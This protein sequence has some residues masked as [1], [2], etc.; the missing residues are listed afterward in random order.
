MGLSDDYLSDDGISASFNMGRQAE[1]EALVAH[2]FAEVMKGYPANPKIDEKI[3]LRAARIQGR[4]PTHTRDFLVSIVA[5]WLS[6]RAAPAAA[7][8]ARKASEDFGGLLSEIRQA[9]VALEAM[10]EALRFADTT[11]RGRYAQGLAQ[12]V[13]GALAGAQRALEEGKEWSDELIDLI[14]AGAKGARGIV[15]ALCHRGAHEALAV[16]VARCWSD[17]G[18]SLSGGKN[19]NGDGIDIFLETILGSRTEAE[20]VLTAVRSEDK[21]C[22]C[23]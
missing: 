18:L 7:S 9:N 22:S 3:R 16:N 1:A 8:G 5:Q 14:P 11:E 19:G 23:Q 10:S 15:G 12:L 13:A 6:A 21:D 2:A 20:K 17:R 4:M